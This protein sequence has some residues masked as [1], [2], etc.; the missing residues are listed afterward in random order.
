MDQNELANTVAALQSRT[1]ALMKRINNL[2]HRAEQLEHYVGM[3]RHTNANWRFRQIAADMGL[4]HV[5][6]GKALSK[7][8]C[9]RSRV[10]GE[11][12]REVANG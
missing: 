8:T 3:R 1:E 5:P 12:Y 11:Q 9:A 2:V 10:R 7:S 6:T 4:S